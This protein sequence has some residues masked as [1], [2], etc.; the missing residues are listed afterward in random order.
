MDKSVLGEKTR[1]ERYTSQLWE[2]LR[3]NSLYDDLMEFSD[4]LPEAVPCELHKD[5]CTR[6]K[7]DL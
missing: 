4:V 3:T 5:K 7:I 2:S 1:I 6:H